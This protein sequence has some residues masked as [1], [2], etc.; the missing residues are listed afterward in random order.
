MTHRSLSD[1]KGDEYLMSDGS[2][3][4]RILERWSF[5]ALDAAS[6]RRLRIVGIGLLILLLPAVLWGLHEFYPVGADWE[7]AFFPAMRHFLEPYGVYY[8]TSPPWVL[9][10]LPHALLDLKWSNAINMCLNILALAALIWRFKGGPFAFVLTFTSPIFLKLA[11]ANNVDWIPTL[12]FLIPPM[13]GMPLLAL[14]PQVLGGAALIW[15][16]RRRFSPLMLVPL[17]VVIILSLI[18]WGFWLPDVNGLPDDAN[19]WNFAPWP[20]G[21]PVGIYLIYQGWKKDDE[22][23]AAAATP[24]FVPYFGVHSLAPLLALLACKYRREAI[25]LYAGFWF[26]LIVESRRLALIV[27][28]G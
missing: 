17:A 23:L 3:A 2:K 5:D 22:I 4:Q 10:L 9:A 20:F 15:W 18:I 7:S 27:P 28:A 16:K 13:W 8:F 21:I 12:A 11:H 26:Y 24:F 25:Y 6:Q 19:L 14:K 1:I